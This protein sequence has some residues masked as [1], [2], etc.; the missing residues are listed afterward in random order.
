MDPQV[1]ALVRQVE[2]QLARLTAELDD[3]C[4]WEGETAT[5]LRIQAV[6]ADLVEAAR[7]HAE[8][9]SRRA[10]ERRGPPVAG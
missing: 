7:R 4:D 10:P 9:L 6:A 2:R 8:D 1:R 3:V 5:L